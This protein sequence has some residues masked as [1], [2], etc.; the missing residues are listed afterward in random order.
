M[1]TAIGHPDES[2]ISGSLLEMTLYEKQIRGALYGSSNAPHDIPRLVELYSAGLLKLDELVTREYSLDQINEATRICVQEET[3][4]GSSGS[5]EN[6]APLLVFM[7]LRRCRLHAAGPLRL[8]RVASSFPVLRTAS[9][10]H[11]V[12]NHPSNS[13]GG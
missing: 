12:I 11:L 10:R 13:L 1:V 7:S 2:S 9:I 3:F 8:P 4:E 6:H 5:E